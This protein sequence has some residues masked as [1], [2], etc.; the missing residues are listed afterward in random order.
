VEGPAE[1][2]SQKDVGDYRRSTIR[3]YHPLFGVA[4]SGGAYKMTVKTKTYVEP[5]KF[6]EE[7]VH[8]STKSPK[9]IS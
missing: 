1:E 9:N 8:P 7:G 6:R 4:I 2:N 5:F 3:A